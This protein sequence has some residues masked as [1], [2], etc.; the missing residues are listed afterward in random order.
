VVVQF[1]GIFLNLGLPSLVGGDVVKAYAVT[2]KSDVPFKFGLASVLQDRAA[3][4][5]A[6]LVYGSIAAVSAGLSWR[7]IPL[8]AMYGVVWLGCGL[9]FLVVW[10]G[11]RVYRFFR[12]GGNSRL[13]RMVRHVA[14]FHETLAVMRLHASAAFHVALLSLANSAL[15]IYIVSRMCHATHHSVDLLTVSALVPL[16]DVL[17][18]MPVS[19]AGLG[20]REWGY[21]QALPLVGVPPDAALAI[22]LSLSAL[23]IARS[24]VGAFFLPW[25]G[26]LGTGYVVPD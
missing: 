6:L 25:I 12:F 1:A 8:P 16:I 23:L 26:K 10:K 17:S 2:S 4:L 14:E 9:V 5:I 11:D 18:M 3:G 19:F 24:L 15:V 21:V 13:Y 7:G 20:I 22:A